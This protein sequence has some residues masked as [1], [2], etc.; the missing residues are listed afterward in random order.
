MDLANGK[1]L[2]EK[3]LNGQG[4]QGGSWSSPVL[5]GGKIYVPNLSGEIFVIKP[6]PE[7]EV[8]ATNSIGDETTC[9]SLAFSHGQVFLR[10]YKALWCFGN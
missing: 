10:T 8:L 9:A 5:V 4:S 6:S 2:A 7:L 3:R 1:K